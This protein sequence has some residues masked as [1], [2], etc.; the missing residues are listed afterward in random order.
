MVNAS[1]LVAAQHACPYQKAGVVLEGGWVGHHP[2]PPKDV[3]EGLA[4]IGRRHHSS[5]CWTAWGV[6][7]AYSQRQFS[8]PYQRNLFCS[9]FSVSLPAAVACPCVAV[10]AE[11]MPMLPEERRYWEGE[12]ARC[13]K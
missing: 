3:V 8:N 9:M 2:K 5:C 4:Y 1:L 10:H 7:G 13:T 11:E 12:V 6:S